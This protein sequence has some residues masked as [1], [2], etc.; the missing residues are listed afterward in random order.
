MQK[1]SYLRIL[2]VFL[3]HLVFIILCTNTFAGLFTRTV[4]FKAVDD[5]AV[6]LRAWDRIFRHK[7]I[8]LF[9]YSGMGHSSLE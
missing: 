1:I 8:V 4:S 3:E 7:K 9:C 6:V 5:I 2:E